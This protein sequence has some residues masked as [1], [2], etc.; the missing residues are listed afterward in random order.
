MALMLGLHYAPTTGCSRTPPL[1]PI[2]IHQSVYRKPCS[3]TFYKNKRL[4]ALL[5]TLLVTQHQLADDTEHGDLHSFTF[6]RLYCLN[7]V[8]TGSLYNKTLLM[9]E[10]VP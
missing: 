9:G 4:L 6:L 7:F 3:I 8:S 2:P 5:V 1:S 10:Q